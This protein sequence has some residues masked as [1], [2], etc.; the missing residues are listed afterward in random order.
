MVALPALPHVAPWHR[1]CHSWDGRG[2]FTAP[3]SGLKQMFSFLCFNTAIVISLFPVLT[4]ALEKH[5]LYFNHI[6]LLDF[7]VAV[8]FGSRLNTSYPKFPCILSC[9]T[10]NNIS[11]IPQS[12]IR[13]KVQFDPWTRLPCVIEFHRGLMG[14]LFFLSLFLMAT[15]FKLLPITDIH[16]SPEMNSSPTGMVCGYKPH[17]HQQYDFDPFRRFTVLDIV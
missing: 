15:Q 17:L 4:H 1:K 8:I 14:T 6:W 7:W 12:L 11:L 16:P 3:R 13:V 2:S 5:N 9:L 10:K